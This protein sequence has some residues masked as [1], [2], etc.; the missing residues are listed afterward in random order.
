MDKHEMDDSLHEQILA[1][2]PRQFPQDSYRR[3]LESGS[4]PEVA[5]RLLG[6]TRSVTPDGQPSAGPGGLG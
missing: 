6:W 1:E 4:T 2:A 5:L 3:L